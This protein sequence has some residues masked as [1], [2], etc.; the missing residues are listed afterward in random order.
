[1]LG[2][3]HLTADERDRLADLKWPAASGDRQVPRS[4]GFDDL[5]GTCGAMRS[6]AAPTGRRCRRGH[7]YSVV[8]GPPALETR[9]KLATYVTDRLAEGWIP[10]QIAGRLRPGVETDLRAGCSETLYGWSYRAGQKAERLA[11][12][13][14]PPCPAHI[15]QRT[16]DANARQTVGTGRLTW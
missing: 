10:E 8:S 2:C 5:A 7:P 3:F 4:S 12:P 11:I 14:P 13:D 9:A 6:T 16:R 15:S 1:M